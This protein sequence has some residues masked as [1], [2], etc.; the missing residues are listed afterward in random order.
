MVVPSYR[1]ERGSMATRTELMDLIINRGGGTWEDEVYGPYRI[2]T[3]SSFTGKTGSGKTAVVLLIAA[4]VALG[5]KIGDID[6]EQGRVLYFAGANPDDVRM[7]W[8]AMSQ[9]LDFD[10]TTID[11]YFI[12]G[13]SRFPRCASA[14]S[15]NCNGSAATSPWSLSIPARGLLR[16]QGSQQQHRN[17]RAWA[18]LPGADR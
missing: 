9:Q 10:A 12:P 7:R 14:S 5:R 18:P 6:V 1:C 11:V 16:R 8:I 15:P 3:A 2:R 13:A 4:S 17:G